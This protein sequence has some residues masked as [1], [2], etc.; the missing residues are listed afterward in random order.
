MEGQNGE[1]RYMPTVYVINGTVHPK[2]ARVNMAHLTQLHQAPTVHGW[3]LNDLLRFPF[4]SLSA[5]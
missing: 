3:G 1:M 2:L 4:F 5:F